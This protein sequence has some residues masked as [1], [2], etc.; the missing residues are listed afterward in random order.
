M[1]LTGA[2]AMTV[3]RLVGREKAPSMEQL[4]KPPKWSLFKAQQQALDSLGSKLPL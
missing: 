2:I 1:S 3:G 4:A